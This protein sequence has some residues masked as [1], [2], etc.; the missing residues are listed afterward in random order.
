MTYF[1]KDPDAVLDYG[2][3]WSDWLFDGDAIASSE[4][5]VPEGL[6]KDS[7]SKSDTV[8]TVWLSGGSVGADYDIT[9]HIA[10]TDGREDDRTMTISVR[11]R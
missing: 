10:T 2:F 1:R 11:Q 8:T 6:T 4:W 5:T 7:Q 3:D 9:N